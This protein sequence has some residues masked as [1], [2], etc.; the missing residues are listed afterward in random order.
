MNEM[1][2]ILTWVQDEGI[3]SGQPTLALVMISLVV[4]LTIVSLLRLVFGSAGCV[5][6]PSGEVLDSLGS[7]THLEHRSTIALALSRGD[8]MTPPAK[9]AAMIV[10]AM[11]GH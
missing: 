3:N 7:T 1:K 8:T 6:Q 4:S 2:R 11:F 9:I 10:A 5:C